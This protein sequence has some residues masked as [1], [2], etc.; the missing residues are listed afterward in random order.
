MTNFEKQ[1]FLT[2]K[3]GIFTDNKNK[4]KNCCNINYY[5]IKQNQLL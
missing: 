2:N 4:M 3:H 1:S 5:N